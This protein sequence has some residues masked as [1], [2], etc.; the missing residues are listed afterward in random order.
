MRPYTDQLKAH[1]LKPG[2]KPNAMD[3]LKSLPMQEVE[4]K[5]GSVAGW[6]QSS[7]GAET[8]EPIWT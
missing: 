7:R 5:L 8:A 6:S 3:D 4:E 2:Y 1:E